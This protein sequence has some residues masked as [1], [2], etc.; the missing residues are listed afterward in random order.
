[1]VLNGIFGFLALLFV[2]GGIVGSE[3]SPSSFMSAI[4]VSYLI[5]VVTYFYTLYGM[6][7]LTERA[8]IVYSAFIGFAAVLIVLIGIVTTSKTAENLLGY[9]VDFAIIPL[10]VYV[11]NLWY[12]R[13]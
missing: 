6:Y 3:K 10:L 5:M 1:M 2:I 8:K 9:S 11:A 4:V 7:K 12:A 13:K